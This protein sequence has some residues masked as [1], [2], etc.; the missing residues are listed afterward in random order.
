MLLR[1][2]DLA[3]LPFRNDNCGNENCMQCL[4]LKI[5]EAT[6]GPGN[7]P[8]I[9]SVSLYKMN[10]INFNKLLTSP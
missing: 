4:E 10:T 2:L 8:I 6:T 5:S 7:L 1:G 3:T 9:K